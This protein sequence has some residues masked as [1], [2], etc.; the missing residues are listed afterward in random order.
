MRV[1][2]FGVT[3]ND[4]LDGRVDTQG[5]KSDAQEDLHHDNQ[6]E[7][8]MISFASSRI[9]DQISRARKLTEMLEQKKKNVDNQVPK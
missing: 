6:Q 8:I 4:S 2:S 7:I 3:V 5:S 9:T 1:G